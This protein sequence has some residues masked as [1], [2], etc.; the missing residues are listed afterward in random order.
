[1]SKNDLDAYLWVKRKL[2]A[3][4]VTKNKVD[5][6]L[7][8]ARVEIAAA[9]AFGMEPLNWAKR[10]MVNFIETELQ[11]ER[12]KNEIDGRLKAAQDRTRDAENQTLKD[13]NWNPL[14]DASIYW[15]PEDRKKEIEKGN[16][17]A[18]AVEEERK[19]SNERENLYHKY[20]KETPEEK[21][22][23]AIAIL[24]TMVVLGPEADLGLSVEAEAALSILG[25]AEASVAVG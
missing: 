25:E 16:P 21:F 15:Y 4:I 8:K 10:D 17:Y 6:A 14:K 2:Y 3:W 18:I 1:M 22:A 24:L 13:P 23:G 19:I 11:F 9:K 7:A 20:G 12:E 5:T